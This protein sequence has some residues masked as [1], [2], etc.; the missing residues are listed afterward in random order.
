MMLYTCNQKIY[1]LR[2]IRASPCLSEEMLSGC[3]E[4]A[5]APSLCIGYEAYHEDRSRRVK[6]DIGPRERFRTVSKMDVKAIEV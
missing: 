6:V 3:V 1:L 4:H 2:I 5:G